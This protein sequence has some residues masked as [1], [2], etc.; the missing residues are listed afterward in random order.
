M[1]IWRYIPNLITFDV[2]YTTPWKYHL[3]FWMIFIPMI[4]KA[5]TLKKQYI[6]GVC[7]VLEP[8]ITIVYCFKRKYVLQLLYLSM[9][10]LMNINIWF[11]THFMHIL[12]ELPHQYRYRYQWNETK[13]IL[14]QVLKDF[15]KMRYFEQHF[16]Q[17]ILIDNRGV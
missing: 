10:L 14:Y 11:N 2:W 12:I 15:L 4:S 9:H 7:H 5:H 13:F 6:L 16:T 3:S 8:I 17:I 1:T